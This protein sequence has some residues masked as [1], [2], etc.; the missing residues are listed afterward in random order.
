MVVARAL[1]VDALRSAFHAMNVP[2]AALK[3]GALQRERGRRPTQARNQA[4]KT[5]R[6]SSRPRLHAVYLPTF[7]TYTPFRTALL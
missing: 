1:R 7:D 4:L 3:D 2:G 6:A 5:A